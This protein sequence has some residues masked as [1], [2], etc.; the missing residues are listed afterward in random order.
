MNLVDPSNTATENSI[1]FQH[2]LPFAIVK[3]EAIV[4]KPE[5][6]FIPPEALEV[7]LESFEGPLDLLLYLIRKQKFEILD[8]PIFQ[9]TEQYMV[10]VELMKTTNLELAGEYLV[11]A[12]VLA[13]IKSRCL[14]PQ[15]SSE[16]DD[17]LDPRI[18][19]AKRLKE[20]EAFKT[21]AQQLDSIERDERD[22]FHH[23]VTLADNF[24]KKINQPDID[25]ND[26]VIAFT[27]ILKRSDNF[28]QHE[29]SAEALSTRER[30]SLILTRLKAGDH[31]P[32]DD[33]FDIQEGRAGVVVTFIAIL[34][35]VKEKRISMMQNQVFSVIYL[36]LV[37]FA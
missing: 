8:L 27:A 12:A 11:M 10:Y 9:I 24:E 29:I 32:L 30:M 16:D 6:L 3:G 4:K 17:E 31:Y 28:K 22:F 20:Y 23:S 5:D 7:I 36:K 13:E 15:I 34:E 18:E 14:L 19:L 33:F 26:L 2:E 25:L 21:A 35:L 37:D 1:P